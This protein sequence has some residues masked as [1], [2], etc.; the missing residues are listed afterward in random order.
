MKNRNVNSILL[1]PI[2]VL[3]K[4]DVFVQ[5]SIK[6]NDLYKYKCISKR[7][8]KANVISY[9]VKSESICKHCQRKRDSDFIKSKKY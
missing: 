5:F 7:F 3:C 4:C 8:N 1:Q 6:H 2:C 9:Y